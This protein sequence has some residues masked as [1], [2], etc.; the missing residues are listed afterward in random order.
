LLAV[1]STIVHDDD[2][3][4]WNALFERFSQSPH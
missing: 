2:L 4:R 3:V 1:V